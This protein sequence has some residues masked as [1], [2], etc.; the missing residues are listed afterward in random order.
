V[1]DRILTVVASVLKVPASSLTDV[2]SP[3][4]V[5]TW[6]S[7]QHL[8]VILAL[9]E[10]FGIQFPADDIDRLQTVGALVTSVRERVP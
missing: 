1:R 7:L 6:D 4:T 3:D 5:D 8:Q 2:S 10:E 9:E